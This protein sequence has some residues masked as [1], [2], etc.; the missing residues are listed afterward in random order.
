MERARDLFEQC[1]EG[2]P[3]S[4]AKTFYLLYARFEE[5]FGL[6]RHALAIYERATNAVQPTE[7]FEVRPDS[8][9]LT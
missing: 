7:K 5:Q 4:H 6:A 9:S 2:C 1:L 3:E 8:K